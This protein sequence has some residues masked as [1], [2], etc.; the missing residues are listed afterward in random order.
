MAPKVR[1]TSFVSEMVELQPTTVLDMIAHFATELLQ[2]PAAIGSGHGGGGGGSGFKRGCGG[3]W[4][5][6]C[7]DGGGGAP[8]ASSLLSAGKA[9]PGGGGLCWY[10]LLPDL[11]QVRLP[12]CAAVCQS[13]RRGEDF[14]QAVRGGVANR[15][16]RR[17]IAAEHAACRRAAPPSSHPR[18]PRL[19]PSRTASHWQGLC[20]IGRVRVRTSVARGQLK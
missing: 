15:R 11:N 12:C 9:S 6:C 10:W 1:P 18:A 14:E 3:C 2:A 20:R 5:A 16:R 19:I 13:D 7:G 8:S 17:R 4:M